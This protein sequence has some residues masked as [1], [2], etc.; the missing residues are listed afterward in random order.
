MTEIITTGVIR[1]YHD[2][3]KTKL[4]EEYFIHNNKIEGIYKYYHRNGQLRE[5]INYIDGKRN[6][7]KWK[8]IFHF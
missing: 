3:E 2:I 4:K 8:I 7:K 1:T 5:E 6:G